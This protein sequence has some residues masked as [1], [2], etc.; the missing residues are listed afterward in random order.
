MAQQI[1]LLQAL[2]EGREAKAPP[3]WSFQ[4]SRKGQISTMSTEEKYHFRKC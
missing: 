4:S 3:L 1:S 2:Q